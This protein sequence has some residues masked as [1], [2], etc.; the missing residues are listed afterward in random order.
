[1]RSPT[2]APPPHCPER[3]T[4]SQNSCEDHSPPGARVGCSWRDT[5]LRRLEGGGSGRDARHLRVGGIWTPLDETESRTWELLGNR[6]SRV[7]RP[8][9]GP[10]PNAGRLLQTRGIAVLGIVSP[11]VPVPGPRLTTCLPMASSEVG[12]SLLL[13]LLPEHQGFS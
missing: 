4:S 13:S 2:A 1:M 7:R 10:H 8:P 3:P 5:S 12:V 9:L 11:S 6:E